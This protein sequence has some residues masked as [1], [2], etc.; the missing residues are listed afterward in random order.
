MT[1]SLA[2]GYL[3]Y[4]PAEHVGVSGVLAAVTVGLIVGHRASEL[5]TAA[6]RLRG[7]AFWEVLVFL[8]NAVL[9]LLVGLQLPSILA[10]QD[11]SALDL[12]GLGVLVGAVVIGTRMLWL[13]TTPYVIR[14]LDRRPSQVARRIGWRAADA[15]GVER[16]ARLGVARRGAR[17][18]RGLPR[19]RPAALADALRDLRDPRRSRG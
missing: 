11:R 3:A 15:R 10:Q 12:I 17:A 8:L 19:A 5:S 9:F 1:I 7:Y 4:L 2:A 16:P 18:A 14:A 13:N 6:G